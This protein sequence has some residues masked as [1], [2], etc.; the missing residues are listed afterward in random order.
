V[1]FYCIAEGRRSELEIYPFWIKQ[2]NP[3]YIKVIGIKN[4][5]QNNHYCIE[6]GFGHPQIKD[7]IIRAKNII[8]KN[9]INI[10]YFVIIIDSEE[11]SIEKRLEQ[12]QK[13]VNDNFDNVSFKIEIIIQ[14]ICIE[15][16]LLGN[17]KLFTTRNKH[18]SKLDM[19]V[20][21]YNVKVKDPEKIPQLSGDILQY[22]NI[23][24]Q[25]C[26]QYLRKLINLRADGR[27]SYSKNN[28]SFV[29][30]ESYLKNMI[31]RNNEDNH[32]FYFNKMR[33]FFTLR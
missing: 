19:F 29:V 10:E 21:F 26:F 13:L 28:P 20:D 6:S 30:N 5:S 22:T 9:N 14:P 23:R 17:K 15:S 16:W 1:A 2:F 18:D 11:N 32:L 3:K 31:H 4:I 24:A 12:Y 8:L 7:H 27:C 33:E 25:Y